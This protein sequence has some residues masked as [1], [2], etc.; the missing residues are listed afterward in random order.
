MNQILTPRHYVDGAFFPAAGP[1]RE[2]LNPANLEVE[3]RIADATPE[4]IERVLGSARGARQAWAALDG[5]TRANYL[6][7]VADAI[8]KGD[9]SRIA[10]LMTREMGKPYPEALG[11][12]ANVPSIYRYYAEIARDEVGRVAAPIQPGSFQYSHCYP[13]GVSV[14]IMPFNFPLLLLSWGLAASLAAGNVA[15]VKPAESTTLCT[16]AFLETIGEALP[17]GVLSGLAGG[18]EV[19]RALVESERTHVVAFTGSVAAA[20]AVGTACAQRFKPCLLEAGGNDPLIVSHHAPLEVA[21][22]G[23]VTAAFHLSGQICTSSE[24]FLVHRDVYDEFVAGLV[25]GARALRVGP[26]LEKNEIGPLVSQAARDKVTRLVDGAVAAGARLEI[27]GRIPPER[28]V[29]WFYEPTVLS[30]VTPEMEIFQEEVFGPV[31]SVCKVDSFEQAL[32]IANSSQF[33]LGASLFTTD[34][35]ESMAFAEGIES[36]MAWVNNPLVDNDALPFGG[37]KNS[38]L[39]SALG[40]QGLDAF[41]RSKMVVID[42]QPKIH[43]WWYPYPDEVFFKELG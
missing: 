35:A 32:E 39:G 12:L 14:H 25:K 10:E 13:Y 37:W 33:G 22:A 4:E 6:H 7:R 18:A 30:G 41:R 31:A 1:P 29:G 9:Q 11:E 17:S 40:R 43:D 8:E 2:I 26:G 23:S 38:G 42:A 15:V 5:K 20:R 19:G 3:G 36:G 24:R 34:L 28:P 16:W 21:V 27:G